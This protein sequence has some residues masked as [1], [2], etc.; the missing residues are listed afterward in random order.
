MKRFY[1]KKNKRG[2]DLTYYR[3]RV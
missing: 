3:I 2:G 1:L